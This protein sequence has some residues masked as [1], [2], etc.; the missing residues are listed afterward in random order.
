MDM[1]RMIARLLHDPSPMKVRVAMELAD[2]LT[3]VPISRG[4]TDA[5]LEQA[6]VEQALLRKAQRMLARRPRRVPKSPK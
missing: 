5:D 3:R 2:A 6:A 4:W 1:A